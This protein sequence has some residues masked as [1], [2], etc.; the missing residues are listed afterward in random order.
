MEHF[1]NFGYVKQANKQ[2]KKI[3]E[4]KELD[5]NRGL[6]EQA[7]RLVKSNTPKYMRNRNL[8]KDIPEE[9]G[10]L[11]AV[12]R[13]DPNRYESMMAGQEGDYIYRGGAR[14]KTNEVLRK[15]K[16]Y[17]N[18][19]Y[20]PRTPELVPDKEAF[21]DIRKTKDTAASSTGYLGFRTDPYKGLGGMMEEP[22]DMLPTGRKSPKARL[23]Y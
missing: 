17:E 12:K 14:R 7:E 15:P 23:I 20:N 22:V 9:I 6:G 11:R 4:L 21:S 13:D 5:V 8:K 16:S 1:A 10:T 3:Q 19:M 2:L 18:V